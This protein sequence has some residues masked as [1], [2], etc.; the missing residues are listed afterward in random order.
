MKTQKVLIGLLIVAL[1]APLVMASQREPA[2]VWRSFAEKLEAGA[3]VRVRLIDHRQVKGHVVMVDGDILRLKPKTRVPVPIRDLQFA[4]IESIDR[5]QEGWS[6]GK[7]I[8]VG[9]GIGGGIVLGV[10]AAIFALAGWD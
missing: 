5:Q 2:E 8:L 10:A 4:D 6:P 9:A 1:T 3:F 7:K